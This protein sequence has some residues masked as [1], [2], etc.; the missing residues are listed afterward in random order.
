[1]SRAAVPSGAD[2]ARNVLRDAFGRV[3][4]T[5]PDVLAGLT[6]EDLLWRPDPGANSIAWLVWHLTR[7][8]DDHVADLAGID[9][10]WIADGWRERFDL[11]YA[12]HAVGYGMDADEVGAFVVTD[13]AVL[14]GYHDAVH[15]LTLRVLG[16]LDAEG[17]SR[18]VD[19]RW[20]PPVT[21]SVRLVSVVND[22]SQHVGQAAYV[23][24]MLERRRAGG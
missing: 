17:L 18:V 15:R 21:A 2:L 20:D 16:D 3:A 9:Q 14:S 19:R 12:A 23:R 10:A 6:P 13:P 8:Q 24:G 7:V 11:P 22:T 4:E 5:V 1:M